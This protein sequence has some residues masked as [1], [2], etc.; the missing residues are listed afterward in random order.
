MFVFLLP[1]ALLYGALVLWPVVAGVYNSMTDWRGFGLPR[2][3]VGL[4]NYAE[5]LGDPL[6]WN[7]LGNSFL[8]MAINVPIRLAIALVLA[9]I[10]TEATLRFRTAFRT[11][12]FLPVVSATAVIG[13]VMTF[14]LSPFN[15]PINLALLQLGL[16]SRP[17]DFL[18]GAA[19]ALATVAAVSIW[20]WTGVTLI[21]WLAA[22]QSIPGELY[23]AAKVDGANAWTAFRYITLP[24]LVPFAVVI[25][26]ISIVNMLQVF[27]L[28][29]TM[30]AGGPFFRTEVMEVY[31]FRHG[32]SSLQG[33]PRLGY[34]S[35]A[36]IMFGL[37]AATIALVYAGAVRFSQRRRAEMGL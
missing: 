15:G 26:L 12:I 21:Y 19:T 29:Q 9:V 8:F 32:F 30:T 34:A 28:V 22:L 18:G 35:S 7:S 14:I 5:L 37:A 2:E 23:E 17:V 20:K 13:V 36:A 10:L 4:D 6:F 3:F 31:I 16:L 27:D 24:L 25:A 33:V 1:L 11:A